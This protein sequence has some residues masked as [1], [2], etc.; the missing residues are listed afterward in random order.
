MK[1]KEE[2]EKNVKRTGM[3]RVGEKIQGEDTGREMKR[4]LS[5]PKKDSRVQKKKK[6]KRKKKDHILEYR[7]RKAGQRFLELYRDM[8]F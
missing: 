4:I 2:K 1:L 3:K 8:I 7:F 5:K 6:Q